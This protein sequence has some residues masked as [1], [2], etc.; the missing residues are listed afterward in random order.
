MSN[1][2]S[3]THCIAMLLSEQTKKN[4]P[5]TEMSNRGRGFSRLGRGSLGHESPSQHTDRPGPGQQTHSGVGRGVLQQGSHSVQKG[6][7]L[8]GGERGNSGMLIELI[9]GSLSFGL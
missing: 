8:H 3:S 6:S 1:D 2:A 4:Q 7:Q 9:R 5:A